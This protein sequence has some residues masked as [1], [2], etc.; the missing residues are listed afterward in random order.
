[1]KLLYG[2]ERHREMIARNKGVN[3]GT[4]KV[5][6]KGNL[7]VTVIKHKKWRGF[8]FAN[9]CSDSGVGERCDEKD[10]QVICM[11]RMKKMAKRL[12]MYVGWVW[13]T[14]GYRF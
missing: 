1:M 10:R 9:Q 4:G 12:G 14:E 6:E 2:R 5:R 3:G 8:V 7:F 13:V 11:P